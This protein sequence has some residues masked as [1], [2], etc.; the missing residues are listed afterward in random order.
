MTTDRYELDIGPSCSPQRVSQKDYVSEGGPRSGRRKTLSNLP[1]EDR[2]CMICGRHEHELE[3]F[4]GTDD[5]FFE[6]FASSKLNTKTREFLP[7]YPVPNLE[8]RD[9]FARPGPLWAIHEED[10]LG[11]PL[12]EREY[13]DMRY[14]L[15]IRELEMHEESN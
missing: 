13:I 6:D 11:R 5:F 14:K 9:C 7:G 15:E 2:E 1:P 4:G 10:R 3:A 8:C 12:T